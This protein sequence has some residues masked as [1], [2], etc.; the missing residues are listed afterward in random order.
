[1]LGL[2]RIP[3]TVLVCSFCNHREVIEGAAPSSDEV[4]HH[5]GKHKTNCVGYQKEVE[6]ARGFANG[7][8][9]AMHRMGFDMRD[10]HIPFVDEEVMKKLR[11][12]Q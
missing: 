7:L 10:T 1:M 2:R 9:T 12:E 6:D 5:I 3:S 4:S 8:A 11:E